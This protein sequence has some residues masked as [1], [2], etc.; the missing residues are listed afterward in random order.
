MGRQAGLRGEST[1][2]GVGERDSGIRE[3]VC[4]GEPPAPSRAQLRV[5]RARTRTPQPG[6]IDAE[7]STDSGRAPRT[8]PPELRSR[9][10]SSPAP[11]AGCGSS[12]R[13]RAPGG[14]LQCGAHEEDCPCPRPRLSTRESVVLRRRTG[15]GVWG[16][17]SR[18]RRSRASPHPQSVCPEEGA[19]ISLGGGGGSRGVGM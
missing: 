16:G 18:P 11:S 19:G 3:R 9:V 5:G 4:D 15:D 7:S 13:G 1:E 10:C 17:V 12:G 14:A 8:V 2:G 6:R